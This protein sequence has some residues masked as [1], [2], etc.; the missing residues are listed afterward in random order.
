MFIISSLPFSC[1]YALNVDNIRFGERDGAVRMVIELS[2]STDFRVFALADPYRMVVDLPEFAWN[3]GALSKPSSID[4][5]G[6]RHGK[7]QTGVSRIVI[8][9]NQ[10]VS[11]KN[12]FLLPRQD[13]YPDR[14]VVDY[15]PVGLSDFES[16]KTKVHGTLDTKTAAITGA[17]EVRTAGT[18]PSS[19]PVPKT[20]VRKPLIVIDPGHGGQDPGAIN[21]REFKE[22]NVVL[23]LAKDLKKKLESSGKYNVILT[24]D[25]DIFIRL[26]DRVSFARHHNADLFVSIHADS[27]DRSNVHGASIY[28]LS[29][30]AS[31]AQTAKLAAR[32]NRVDLIAGIDLTDED[33]EVANILVDLAMRDTMNQSKFF[34]NTVVSQFRKG[35]VSTLDNPHRFAG[36]AV[37]KAPDIPSVL[38]EAGFLSNRREASMLSQHSYRNKV[39]EAIKNGIDA[40]FERVRLNERS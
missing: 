17:E 25:K 14:L 39:T 26:R 31:D 35:G 37:L 12:A 2:K 34:A 9:L 3:A 30:K 18:A 10:P 7:L 21:G 20:K 11:V 15:V 27:I 6:I 4:V 19:V 38:I 24:R 8:D 33:Q 23:A 40:Y 5:R 16:T 32:E 13:Q 29:E 22:K 1:A 36:F 28:T